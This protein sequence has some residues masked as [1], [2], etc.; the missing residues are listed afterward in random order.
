MNKI[1]VGQTIGQ[2]YG[3]S[4]GRYLP[5]LGILWLPMLVL[6]VLGYFAFAPVFEGF[7]ALIQHL[8]QF[9][10]AE[11]GNPSA[12]PPFPPEFFQMF[13][14]IGLF[15]LVVFVF[16]AIIAV[17]ITKEALGLR[18]GP[19][20]VYLS[21]GSAEMLVIGGYLLVIAIIIAGAIAFEIVAVVVGI[22]VGVAMAGGGTGHVDPR[23]IAGL[24]GLLVIGFEIAYLYFLI[25]LS[26]F[27]VPVT[28][29]ENRIGVWRSWELTKGNVWRI[30]GISLA[31]LLPLLVIEM[32]AGMVAFGPAI[33]EF[34]S[35]A[36][37]SPATADAHAAL[38]MKSF[39][40]YLP[41]MGAVG[42]VLAPIV[43]GLVL[44]PAAFAYRA[45]VPATPEGGAA[46]MMKEGA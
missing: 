9:K 32:I 37:N 15:D 14:W 42:F 24:V 43:Y 35:A 28:V 38:L 26:Y 34:A 25:R 13:R 23:L 3:F 2:A 40:Q 31:I 18:T 4:F 44:S 20:F 17:G 11:H 39:A 1:P 36:A 30:V 6:G 16:F 5:L 8:Q 19:R 45:L 46:P 10:Q 41:F 29:A 33:A 21:F 12:M 22:I 7:P 27:L